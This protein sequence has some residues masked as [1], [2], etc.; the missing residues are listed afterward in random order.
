MYL[1]L[2]SSI[3]VMSRRTF[4][5]GSLPN[6]TSMV[7]LEVTNGSKR[8]ITMWCTKWNLFSECRYIRDHRPFIEVYILNS[9]LCWSL[10]FLFS[11]SNRVCSLLLYVSFHI[12]IIS[13]FPSFL[14]LS[15]NPFS[16]HCHSSTLLL[17]KNS[18][19]K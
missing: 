5:P 7:N 14:L 15:L 3:R 12:L 2:V 1:E 11:F 9:L 18:L 16:L 6:A 13:C 4:W 8:K 19:L 10:D 17:L